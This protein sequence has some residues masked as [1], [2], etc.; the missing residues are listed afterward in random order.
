MAGSR[1]KVS[2]KAKVQMLESAILN[3]D[4]N[5]VQ[6]LF[7]E[8]EKFE[9]TARA[10][11]FACRYSTLEMVKLLV[12][13]NATFYYDYTPAI[14]GKY[15]V[16]TETSGG[17]YFADYRL[18]IT[19]Q[20]LIDFGRFGHIHRSAPECLDEKEIKEKNSEKE[21]LS[22]LQFLKEENVIEPFWLE[23]ILYQA[24]LSGDDLIYE[25]LKSEGI[26]IHDY[27]TDWRNWDKLTPIRRY[28]IR[29]CFHIA[30]A[31]SLNRGTQNYERSEF[32]EFV[33]RS[34]AYKADSFHIKKAFLELSEMLRKE[35]LKLKVTKSLLPGIPGDILDGEILNIL[36]ITSLTT[37][38]LFK[39][40]LDDDNGRMVSWILERG[41]VKTDKQRD[42]F[43]ESSNS[44]NKLEC[45]A[46][47]M[48]YKN[49]T[50]DP[51]IEARR[52][53]RKLSVTPGS[54][55]DLKMT[56]GVKKLEDGTLMITSYKGDSTE[57]HIPE[58]IGKKIVSAIDENAFNI[59]APR[60]TPMQKK[61]REGIELI[62]IPGTIKI[63]PSLLFGNS[64]YYFEKRRR[65]SPVLRKVILNKGIEEI[66]GGAFS[67]CESLQEI[68]IPDTVIKI[69]QG[70]FERCT[71]LS[72]IELPTSISILPADLF[73]HSGLIQFEMSNNVTKC[74]SSLF[75]GCRKLKSISLSNGIKK[76]S[77]QM[78]MNCKALKAIDIPESV[79]EIEE[80]AFHSSGIEKC[81]IP[82]S[83]NKIGRLAFCD[84]KNLISI[85]I[86]ETV[87]L[88]KDCFLD[89]DNLIR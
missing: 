55:A 87:E 39:K 70:A 13:N 53:L 20:I 65:S 54:A 60:L 12:R 7:S 17:V 84:C 56:W 77:S 76:I 58:K 9:F 81:D 21:R 1:K 35:G 86:P 31:Y 43:I 37:T 80:H 25:Y 49:R 67:G 48:D 46:V 10:L 24:L 73:K 52:E 62:E 44:Q 74:G 68:D 14:I 57:V 45:R 15:G 59:D 5:A 69:Y 64:K 88:G 42:Q 71:S 23:S 63:V 36:D 82:L 11:G 4:I 19:S 83:V 38:D 72:S 61:A 89:C 66:G 51:E 27:E 22:I 75:E 18:L 34:G 28:D 8:Y 29:F 50:A 33:F 41:Y 2:E 85:V 78:F 30:Y 47:L 32:S 3:N 6:N 40:A 79:T 26:A 16:I